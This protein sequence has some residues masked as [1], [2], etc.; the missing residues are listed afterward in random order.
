MINASV[1]SNID[2]T[3]GYFDICKLIFG[4]FFNVI[5]CLFGTEIEYAYYLQ[6]VVVLCV[7]YL[8]LNLIKRDNCSTFASCN[9]TLFFYHILG[10]DTKPI[11]VESLK[12]A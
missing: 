7:L 2:N 10:C 11:F 12:K 1:S 6:N 9:S 5:V 4:V 3:F 8:S